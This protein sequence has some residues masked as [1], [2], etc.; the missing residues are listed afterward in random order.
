MPQSRGLPNEMDQLAAMCLIEEPVDPGV[1]SLRATPV[2]FDIRPEEK[3]S[4]R[5]SKLSAWVGS[6]VDL[7][8][9]S[10][11][12]TSSPRCCTERA[13]RPVG[14]AYSHAST[15]L[16]P[17]SHIPTSIVVTNSDEI[18]LFGGVHHNS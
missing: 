5:I 1:S 15:H 6:W 18:F 16:P 2:L 11:L 17:S 7:D 4:K 14:G 8:M 3:P 10:T 12:H 9:E 13:R